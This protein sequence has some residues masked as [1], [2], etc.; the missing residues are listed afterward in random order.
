[1]KILKDGQN[2]D[3]LRIVII[4]EWSENIESIFG[5]KEFCKKIE[6]D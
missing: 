1:M 3:F 4:F 5:F 6:K 2:N